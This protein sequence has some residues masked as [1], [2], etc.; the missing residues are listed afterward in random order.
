MTAVGRRTSRLPRVGGTARRVSVQALV[1]RVLHGWPR[2]SQV[3]FSS[4]TSGFPSRRCA[5]LR[6]ASLVP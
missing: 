5:P 3:A 6:R 2:L 4:P 1:Q